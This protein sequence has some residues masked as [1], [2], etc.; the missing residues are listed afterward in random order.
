[1]VLDNTSLQQA[2]DSI[3]S[4]NDLMYVVKI[5]ND[6]I[7]AI[8]CALYLY[9]QDIGHQYVLDH[10]VNGLVDVPNLAADGQ[11]LQL[12]STNLGSSTLYC[13]TSPNNTYRE[14]LRDTRYRDLVLTTATVD[15]TNWKVNF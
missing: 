2:R 8:D 5:F 12:D 10:P 11:Q 3:G 14:T 4:N 13:I 15:S 6:Y 1:M 7:Y 9:G